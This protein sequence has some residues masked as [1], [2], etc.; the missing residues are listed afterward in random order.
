MGRRHAR[1]VQRLGLP[2]VGV[3]DQSR[4]ALHDAA[5]ELGLAAD[6]L[7]EDADRVLE[8]RPDLVIVATTASA[9]SL[10]ACAAA[11]CSARFLLCE[12]PLA[13]SLRQCDRIIAA[14]RRHG[15]TLAVNHQMRFMEQYTEPKKL[16]ESLAFGGLRSVTITAGNFGLAM[17]A[18]HYFEMFRYLTG[19]AP[20]HACAWFSPEKVPN[21]RGPQFED[22][23][24]CV[25]LSTASGCR[26]YLDCS[27]DQGHGV[28]VIYAARH[29]QIMVD[30]LGGRMAWTC[31]K[32]EHRG[33]PTTRYGM[34]WEE[35]QRAITPADSLAP[36]Q[37]VLQALLAGD[38]YPTGEQGRLAVAALVA[39]HLSDEGGHRPVPLADAEAAAERVFP[40]A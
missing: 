38:D 34:P 29:G 12:K 36:T 24:G 18:T 33:Q 32:E 6:Q 9:H 10:Y 4:Q 14:C 27:A 28:L 19:E 35:G 5:A 7:H 40:W 39:A 17:N 11:E 37:A 26:F 16:L 8:R 3:C 30:E 20:V 15:T 1:V 31:R 23:A 2:L 22:R 21:P 25:R 13:T